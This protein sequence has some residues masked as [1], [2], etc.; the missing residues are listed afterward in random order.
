[1]SLDDALNLGENSLG[2]GVL[3]LV[4]RVDELM[5]TG[6]LNENDKIDL[7]EDGDENLDDVTE[8]LDDVVG[9]DDVLEVDQD[10]G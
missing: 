3:D 9:G 8:T 10:S 4:C 1:M 5:L 2:F 7:L 6:S